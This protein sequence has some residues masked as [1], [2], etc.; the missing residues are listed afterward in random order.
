MIPLPI[1]LETINK[2]LPFQIKFVTCN[3]TKNT[4]GEIIEIKEAIKSSATFNLKANDMISVRDA[5]G[6]GHPYPVHIHLITEF[7]NQ[8]VAI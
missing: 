2:G 1:A 6:G 5:N 7:N 3:A 4:G 8:K